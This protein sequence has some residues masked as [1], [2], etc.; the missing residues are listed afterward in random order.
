MKPNKDLHKISKL[1]EKK[2]TSHLRLSNLSFLFSIIILSLS[3]IF[4]WNQYIQIKDNFIENDNTHI[5]EVTGMYSQEDGYD[6]VSVDYKENLNAL[7]NKQGFENKYT[8]FVLYQFR[9]GLEAEG[10]EE[11]INLFGLDP[12]G[13]QYLQE[14]LELKNDTLYT[15]NKINDKMTVLVPNV[16]I[17]SDNVVNLD[18]ETEY[19]LDLVEISEDTVFRVYDQIPIQ[20]YYVNFNTYNKIFE[21][22]LGESVTKESLE[23][24]RMI[25]PVYKVFIYV[26]DMTNVEKIA[27]ALN[28]ENYLT[29]FVFQS[30]KDIGESLSSS[31]KLMIIISFVLFIFTVISLF[32]SWDAFIKLWSKDIGILKQMGYSTKEVFYVYSSMIKNAFLKISMI[33]IPTILLTGIIVLKI[34]H[35]SFILI[36]LLALISILYIMEYFIERIYLKKLVKKSTLELLKLNKSFE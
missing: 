22:C 23:K 34:E 29:N 30:F 16:T 28:N 26:D 10:L 9:F 12:E 17:D 27:K 20:P 13:E 33:V 15:S 1:L 3:V 7:L 36:Y 21:M 25:Q 19:T 4:V 32:L 35:I 24:F 8:T 6:S 18:G 5:I 2:S 31:L 14:N 11:P